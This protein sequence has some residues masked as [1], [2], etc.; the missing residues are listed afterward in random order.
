MEFAGIFAKRD[1]AVLIPP[2]S[3]S[4]SETVL[5]FQSSLGD[6]LLKGIN[7]IRRILKNVLASIKNVRKLPYWV[8]SDFL[9]FEVQPVSQRV[10]V[11]LVIDEKRERKRTSVG[12]ILIREKRCV[13]V[14]V[15]CRD[16]AVKRKHHKLSC[17][18]CEMRR[19][20]VCSEI[21]KNSW[22]YEYRLVENCQVLSC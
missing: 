2:S 10:I 18:L 16:C 6:S 20:N 11:V 7:I 13:V 15:W 21:L 1:V 17:I 4:H 22:T 5:F 3:A 8:R 12:V 19:S 9:P 14:Y